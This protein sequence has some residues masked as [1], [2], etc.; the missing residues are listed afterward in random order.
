MI[1]DCLQQ[2]DHVDT[3]NDSNFTE[4]INAR[5]IPLTEAEMATVSDY[6]EGPDSNTVEI[7]RFNIDL[8]RTKIK[9][10]R[11]FRNNKFNVNYG[12]LRR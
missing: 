2:S 4:L 12:L 10:L 6:L 11:Q 8:T 3:S 9:C 1:N 7:R 5:Y